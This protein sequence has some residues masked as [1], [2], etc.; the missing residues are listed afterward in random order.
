M[1]DGKDTV[2]LDG[3]GRPLSAR[4]LASLRRARAAHRSYILADQQRV[5][6]TMRLMHQRTVDL[7][8]QIKRGSRK[9]VLSIV[10]EPI[11]TR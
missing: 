4:Q 1:L 10:M 3:S 8:E 2:V 11:H 5:A 9:E 6:D 7:E